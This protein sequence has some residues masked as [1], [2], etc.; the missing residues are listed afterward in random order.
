MLCLYTLWAKADYQLGLKLFPCHVKIVVYP[1]PKPPREADSLPL[2]SVH[3]LLK[4]DKDYCYILVRE[5]G[6]QKNVYI[7][8]L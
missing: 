7:L 6:L 3:S 1:N 4:T 5:N 2:L 8:S